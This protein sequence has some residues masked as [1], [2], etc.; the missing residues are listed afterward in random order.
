MLINTQGFVVG[1]TLKSLHFGTNVTQQRYKRLFVLVEIRT[2][3]GFCLGKVPLPIV[4]SLLLNTN[5]D[6]VKLS[7]KILTYVITHE[8]QP[9]KDN[10]CIPGNPLIL[11]LLILVT[12]K[13]R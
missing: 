4:T 12:V 5:K 8:S 3:L 13:E 1:V 11:F 10:V 6:P 7:V 9:T 2:V